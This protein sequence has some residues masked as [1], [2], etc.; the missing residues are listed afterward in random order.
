MSMLTSGRVDELVTG[1]LGVAA[2]DE[3]AL[4]APTVP[5]IPVT[6]DNYSGVLESLPV[7]AFLGDAG[8]TVGNALKRAPNASYPQPNVAHD[9]AKTT[10]GCEERSM[11]YF[12]DARTLERAQVPMQ[13]ERA[14][15]AMARRTLLLGYEYD[16]FVNNIFAAGNWAG[17]TA[18]VGALVGGGGVAWDGAGSTPVD[19]GL[20]MAEL[21]RSGAGVKPDT[22]YMSHDVAQAL[23]TH[24]QTLQLS[25]ALAA[26]LASSSIALP[27]DGVVELYRNWWGLDRLSV[28]DAMY[29]TANPGQA[30][31]LSDVGAGFVWFGCQRGVD[32]ALPTRD[33]AILDGGPASFVQLKEMDFT[34]YMWDTDNPPGRHVA[35]AHSY[36]IV[37]PSTMTVSAYLL[38]GVV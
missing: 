31:S 28:V 24:Q 34:G 9:Y 4:I 33:G 2:Q 16:M 10:Y 26:G 5:F 21:I 25:G 18:A 14:R 13:F 22:C 38:T 6:A 7:A 17:Q 36:T 15:A 11:E 12:T 27:L 19:D 8:Y 35:G 29:N 32:S 23:R 30:A 20:V 3:G 1:F 37:F